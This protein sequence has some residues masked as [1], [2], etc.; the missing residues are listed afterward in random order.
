MSLEIFILAFKE[1]YAKCFA[2]EIHFSHRLHLHLLQLKAQQFMHSSADVSLIRRSLFS[3]L[4]YNNCN[5]I[6]TLPF[7]LLLLLLLFENARSQLRAEN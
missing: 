5:S 2:N 1:K 4:L 7:V 3:N 6:R